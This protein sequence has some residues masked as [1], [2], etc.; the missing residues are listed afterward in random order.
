MGKSVAS[1]TSHDSSCGLI[2]Q[3][4]GKRSGMFE[5]KRNNAR[6]SRRHLRK[7]RPSPVYWVEVRIADFYALELHEPGGQEA[8]AALDRIAKGRVAE[9]RAIGQSYDRVVSACT[10]H[11]VS[12]G[13]RMRAAGVT[14]GG[15]H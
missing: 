11:G 7:R 5:R 6:A 3:G 13:D 4:R 2:D 9:C 12:L 8:K 14:E 10:V 1:L 15:R